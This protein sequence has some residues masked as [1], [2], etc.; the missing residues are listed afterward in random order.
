MIWEL[1]HYAIA[2]GRI[3]DIHARFRDHLPPL[4]A[5]H[6]IEVVGRW[7]ATGDTERASFV[8]MMGYDDLAQREAQWREFYA[9]PQWPDVRARSNGTSDMVT[10]ID[11]T[12]L[13]PLRG[14]KPAVPN[15]AIGGIHELTMI[16]AMNGQAAAVSEELRRVERM[17]TQRGGTVLL[18]ADLV[19]G[20][21]LPKCAMLVGWDDEAHRRSSRNA[22]ASDPAGHAAVARQITLFGAPLLGATETILLDP[23]ADAL[24]RGQLG[25]KPAQSI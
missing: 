8:Y 25:F 11:I 15:G 22:T 6:G 24:P 13:R 19:T 5:R 14:W 10:S 21:G 7:T 18:I 17:L 4:L 9:D 20:S 12:F 2:P 1:R 23:A 16:R 3:A